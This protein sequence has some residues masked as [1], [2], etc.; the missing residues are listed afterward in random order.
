[1]GEELNLIRNTL[2]RNHP[3]TA[4]EWSELRDKVLCEMKKKNVTFNIDTYIVGNCLPA[5]LDA[6]KSYIKYLKESGI[7]PVPSTLI[8]LLKLYYKASKNGI[9][10]TA[11]DEQDIVD[12]LVIPMMNDR[13]DIFTKIN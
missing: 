7:K 1:M 12:M 2:A 4:K 5:Q 13:A 8:Q 9:K 3:P 11:N 10:I 6:G